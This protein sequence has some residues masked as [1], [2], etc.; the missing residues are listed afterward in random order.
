MYRQQMSDMLSWR[1]CSKRSNTCG[2]VSKESKYPE[3]KELYDL[4]PEKFLSVRTMCKDK[5]AKIC[6][7]GIFTLQEGNESLNLL[8]QYAKIKED[9]HA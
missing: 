3:D 7:N 1:P 5:V 9:M 4:K 6:A 8:T 2:F